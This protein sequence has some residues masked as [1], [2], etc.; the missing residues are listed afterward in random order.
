MPKIIVQHFVENLLKVLKV[1]KTRTAL[2]RNGLA[3]L[4]IRYARQGAKAPFKTKEQDLRK[5]KNL[6]NVKFYEIIDHRKK[7]NIMP[8][9]YNEKGKVIG[10]TPSIGGFMRE[11]YTTNKKTGEWE[12][13]SGQLTRQRINQLDKE[14]KI[15]WF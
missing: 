5:N 8:Y 6:T 10:Y 9:K 4:R 3:E 12:S 13:R 11:P 1:L 7:V 2:T 14:K 15:A